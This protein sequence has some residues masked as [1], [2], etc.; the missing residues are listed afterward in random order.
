MSDMFTKSEFNQPIG[1]WNV[2]KVED[3]YWMFPSP[4]FNQ[5]IGNW[6]VRNV[7]CMYGMFR[8]AKNFNQELKKQCVLNFTTEPN[9]SGGIFLFSQGSPLT[10]KNKPK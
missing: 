6:N 3:M 8:N 5:P 4:Q 10:P 9:G 1:N 2:S 7:T